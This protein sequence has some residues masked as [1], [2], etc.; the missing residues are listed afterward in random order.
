MPIEKHPEKTGRQV[1]D[2][3]HVEADQ[4][5]TFLDDQPVERVAQQTQIGAVPN[6]PVRARLGQIGVATLGAA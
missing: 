4:L 5:A 3:H 6:F 2:V 1:F